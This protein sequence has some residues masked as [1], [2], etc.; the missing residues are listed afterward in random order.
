MHILSF[1]GFILISIL[2]IISVLFLAVIRF[3]SAWI[4]IGRKLDRS[5][6]SAYG[7]RQQ[8]WQQNGSQQPWQGNTSDTSSK[9]VSEKIDESEYVEFEEI[10]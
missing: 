7:A 9:A 10:E 2:V 5:Q 3:V 8:Q 4:G 1:I 6:A